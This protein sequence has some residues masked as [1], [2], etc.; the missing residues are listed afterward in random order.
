MLYSQV[1][2]LFFEPVDFFFDTLFMDRKSFIIDS[3][4]KIAS[5]TIKS[6]EKIQSTKN[7]VSD[8]LKKSLNDIFDDGPEDTSV[9]FRDLQGTLESPGS[10]INPYQ[11]DPYDASKTGQKPLKAFIRPPGAASEDVFLQ[12]CTACYKCIDACP[13]RAIFTYADRSEKADAAKSNGKKRKGKS[14]ALMTLLSFIRKNG[15]R[16]T[17]QTL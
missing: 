5:T 4:K 3:G 7:I 10:V 13:Y 14:Q 9:F 17:P 8:T 2:N 12:K 11:W 15:K 6:L 1:K 16:N